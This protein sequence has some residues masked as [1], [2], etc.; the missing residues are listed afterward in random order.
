[1]VKLIEKRVGYTTNRQSP[2]ESREWFCDVENVS[3]YVVEINGTRTI[4]IWEDA[5]ERRPE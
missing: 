4:A 3:L 2:H 1:M 5:V